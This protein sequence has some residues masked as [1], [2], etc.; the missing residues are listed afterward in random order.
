VFVDL[1]RCMRTLLPVH[2]KA[3]PLLSALY[4]LAAA[5]S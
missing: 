2:D 4:G 5:P 3:A 1:S